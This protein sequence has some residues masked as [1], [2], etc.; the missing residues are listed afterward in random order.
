MIYQNTFYAY[1]HSPFHPLSIKV[2]IITYAGPHRRLWMGPQ[3]SF[4][5]YQQ[6][7]PTN[8]GRISSGSGEYPHESQDIDTTKFVF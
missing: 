2:E 3:F 5:T 6:A 7:T 1:L 4:R 8:K